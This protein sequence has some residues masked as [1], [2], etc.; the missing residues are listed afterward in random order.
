MSLKQTI[1]RMTALILFTV[2]ALLLASCGKEADGSAPSAE[3]AKEQVSEPLEE[4]KEETADNAE[5]ASSEE[6]VKAEDNEAGTEPEGSS[7]EPR[8]VTVYRGLVEEMSDAGVA[9]QFMLARINDDEI[10]ELLA[11]SS[12][13]PLDRENTFIYTVYNDEPVLLA[14]VTAGVDGA[15]LSYS[16]KNLIRQ[17]GSMAG[18]ADVYS[19]VTDGKLE[20]KFRAEMV[21]TFETDAAGDEVFSYTV[22]GKE[23]D[24]K[25]Y[26]KQLAAFNAENAPFVAIDCDGLNVMN[27]ENGELVQGTQLAYWSTED[28]LA[29]LDSIAK[30]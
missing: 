24:Q 12:E 28:T 25:E 13:G 27:Y 6:P 10:W 23:V 9:D 18:M 8:Y 22:N 1:K 7:D 2:L 4:Q 30:E 14:S 15:S 11:S 20:E 26:E 5:E 17:T 16:E 19:A 21:N 29:E 3:P